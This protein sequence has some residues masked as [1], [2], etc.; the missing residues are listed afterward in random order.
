MTVGRALGSFLIQA[1]LVGGTAVLTALA[2]CEVAS[3]APERLNVLL[4]TAD[5]LHGDATGAT[6]CPLPDITPNID[7][8]AA[9]GMR[10]ERAHVTTS[11][12]QPSRTT[13]MTGRYCH[14]TG[15][16]GFKPIRD[17]VPTLGE[18]LR[19]DGY[20]QAILGKVNHLTPEERFCWDVK[21]DAAALRGG[22]DP[23][24]Y[25]RHVLAALRQSR[26]ARRPFFVM[27]NTHDPHR[28]FPALTNTAMA[29]KQERIPLVGLD[30]MYAPQEV[31]VPDF[32]PDIPVVREEIAQYY[33]LVRRC[34][35][36]VGAI[37]KALDDAG[38]REST[39]VMFL[40]DN[41]MPF[42]FAKGNCYP[43]ST[44]TPWIVRWPGTVTPNRVEREH[45]ISTIDFTPTVLEAIGLPQIAGMD[46]H[47]FLPLLQGKSQNGRD[48][49]FTTY[50]QFSDKVTGPI[51]SVTNGRYTYIFNA[52][53][54]RAEPFCSGM[55][56]GRSF[57]AMQDAA[58]HDPAV[59]AR[60]DMYLRRVQDELYDV[61]QD[62]CA[63]HNVVGDP[64]RAEVLREL[65][66]RLL[67][68]M[69]ST[70][71]PWLEKYQAFLRTTSKIP[72]S[73]RFPKLK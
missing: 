3:A 13:M 35:K 38:Y 67:D 40:S 43:Y 26:A 44:R 21:V 54:G 23:D 32:L 16:L 62:P 5:D 70:A 50:D 60:V 17:D 71:D 31:H 73:S 49:V 42:P 24:L 57:P 47:S 14:R 36:T 19:A 68:M 37:L 33:T 22:R 1:V 58:K 45:F 15:T 34:D 20:F 30:R 51:R 55:T 56:E 18:S 12:C 66:K 61:E 52:W 63:L 48:C 39:L 65:R 10:F 8:L 7:R 59:A 41:A 11:L 2:W 53:F 27:A 64:A 46:G 72:P 4:I 6:G 69:T 25:Y 29:P 28:P 9:E